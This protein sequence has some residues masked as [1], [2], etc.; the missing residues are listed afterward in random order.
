M[1]KCKNVCWKIKMIN[2]QDLEASQWLALV[3]SVC[4]KCQESNE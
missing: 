4:M 1:I 3:K 2:D